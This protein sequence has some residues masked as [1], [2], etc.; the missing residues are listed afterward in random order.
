[1]TAL[2]RGSAIGPLNVRN[3][4]LSAVLVTPR[5]IAGKFE[6]SLSSVTVSTVYVVGRAERPLTSRFSAVPGSYDPAIHRGEAWV[7]F[8]F[9][10]RFNGLLC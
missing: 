3:R 6:S 7:L 8:F 2:N 10:N 4:P 5:F 9:G 1:L